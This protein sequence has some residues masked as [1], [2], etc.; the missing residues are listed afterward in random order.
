MPHPPSPAA[1]VPPPA[2]PPRALPA[3]LGLAALLAVAAGG[4]LWIARGTHLWFDE[5]YTLEV[6]RRPLPELLHIVAADIHPPLHF[7]LV[8]AWRALGGEGDLWIRSLSIL[9]GVAGVAL[10]VPAGR[11]LFSRRV[12]WLAAALLALHP[13]HAAF[14]QESRAFALLFGLLA[15]ATWTAWRWLERGRPA[16]AVAYVLAAEAAVWTHYLAAVVLAFTAAWGV[17]ALRREPGRIRAWLGLHLSAALLFAPQLPTALVQ[18]ARLR[19]DH[20][21]KDATA[22]TLLNF[23]RQLAMGPLVLVPVLLALAALPLLRRAERRAASLLWCT[24]L[25]PV[26]VLWALSM[27][28]AGLFLERYMFFALPSFALLVAAGVAGLPGRWVPA[29][30]TVVLLAWAA[31]ALSLHG[32][33]PEA[34]ALERADRWLAPRVAPGELVVHAD[35]HSLLYAR[36]YPDDPGTHVL[37]VTAPRLPYYEGEEVIPASWRITPARF[38][39]EVASGRRWWGLH[40]RYGWA[41]AEPATDL[42][43][44]AARGDSIRLDRV[45]LWAGTAAQSV[46]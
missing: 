20:W 26:A 46:R 19:A 24:S 45:F 25:L 3:A 14:S 30:A 12:G 33:Q 35:A 10:L 9:T 11:D 37:L 16:D 18:L 36:H 22:A 44:R 42:L 32:P 5:L 29:A 7:L 27:A 40:E 38:A 13:A 17:L 8:A 41:G 2:A 43:R 21:V 1:P 15:L 23:V 28:H 6:A 4:R 31:H 39:A 34:T